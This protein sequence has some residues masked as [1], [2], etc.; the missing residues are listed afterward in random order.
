MSRARSA[1]YWAA[2]S[3]LCL[4]IHWLC[5]TA[6]F[7]ADDFAW[8]GNTNT[9]HSFHDL[10]VALFT[11]R[12]QGTIRLWSE[13]VFFMAGYSLF[14][15]NVLPFRIVIFATQFASLVLVASIGTRLSGRRAAGFWAAIFWSINSSTMEPLGWVC[16]YNEVLSGF[17]LLL[18]FH[19]LLRYI[20]TGERRYNICQWIAFILGFGALELN[21]VYPLLAASY[22]FLCARAYFRRTLPLFAVSL[23]YAVAHT[24]VAPF[25]KT[26]YYAM[27][28]TSSML[29]T[30]G[31]Y[32]TWSV[33]PTYV[34]E[35]FRI[36]RWKLLAA[37]A[38]ISLG[39]LAF[40]VR[41][42]RSGRRAAL[43][44]LIWY[45]ATIAPMLPLR[46]HLTEYY[47]YL[48]VIGICWLGGWAFAEHWRAAAIFAALYACLQVP[49]LWSGSEWNNNL[50]ERSR[51]LMEGVARAHQLHPNQ[52]ILLSGVDNDQFSNVVRGR[53]FSLVG[54]DHVYIAPADMEHIDRPQDWGSLEDYVLPNSLASR[55]IDRGELVVYDVRGPQLRAITSI[56]GAISRGGTGLPLRID[57]A[58][59]PA[60]E[61]LGP[62]WYPIETDFRWMPKRATLRMGGPAHAGESL[63]MHGRFPEGRELM[64]TVSVDGSALP[65][66]TA[67]SQDFDLAFPL[68]A[69]VVGK[70]EIHIAVEV[71]RTIRVAGDNRDLGATFGT[72]EIR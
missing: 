2:P 70:A 49:R 10:L 16:V 69:S 11:P 40:L 6:W 42:L 18:A 66:V 27:H 64:V 65:A 59:P 63:Y 61:L 38:L 4:L 53:S 57:V 37:I 31:T 22:T 14:G 50:A 51:D 46:D 3:L 34:V 28:F 26:G 56:Y 19:F 17:F 48:P 15:L 5:F 25:V 20:D 44:C 29:G 45:L 39:L 47:A 33:G 68:P 35:P 72:F 36:H 32:W 67:H 24:A 62:E 58:D 8:L 13:R 43:F 21:V 41:K 52:A 7:R 55:A 60:A 54:V 12:A 9:V 30:L 23:V 71:S 1:A